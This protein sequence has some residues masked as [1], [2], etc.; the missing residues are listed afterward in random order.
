M[1]SVSGLQCSLKGKTRTSEKPS[2]WDASGEQITGMTELA[3]GTSA[4]LRFRTSMRNDGGET[5]WEV[6]FDVTEIHAAATPDSGNGVAVT[7]IGR[8]DGSGSDPCSET[9]EEPDTGLS[10]WNMCWVW[11]ECSGDAIPCETT[12]EFELV[13]MSD[14]PVTVEWAV[15]AWVDGF[16]TYS[17]CGGT[18]GRS[19]DV[20]AEVTL[21]QVE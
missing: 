18:C 4:T 13:S 14:E 9:W 12:V 21:E 16:Y 19:D 5:S 7:V 20:D 11:P 6:D 15:F 3:P 1:V 10:R 8:V 2:A 17:R